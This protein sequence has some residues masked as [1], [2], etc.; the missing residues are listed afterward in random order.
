[1]KMSEG[2]LASWEITTAVLLAI[3]HEELEMLPDIIDS[4][5]A[6]IG[7]I[8]GVPGAFDFDFATVQSLAINIF[9]AVASTLKES[10]PTLFDAALDVGKDAAKEIVRK[11]IE[12]SAKAPSTPDIAVMDVHKIVRSVV[13]DRR[14]SKATADAI[15]NAVLAQIVLQKGRK[16][17]S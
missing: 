14:M 5:Q 8:S 3:N 6:P 17:Q 2:Q 1:M 13:I 7:Q 9:N 15:A 10:M 11:R 12:N 16:N 4:T